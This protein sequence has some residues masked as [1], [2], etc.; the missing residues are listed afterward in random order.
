[1]TDHKEISNRSKVEKNDIL[2]GMIGTIG[3]PVI[4]KENNLF[5]IKNVGLF[6]KNEDLINPRY[7]YHYLSSWF[8][9]KIMLD[10]ELIRGTTQK[11]VALGGLRMLPIP[12]PSLKEQE[13]IIK[14][15]ESRLSVCENIEATIEEAL[16]KAEALESILKK[17]FE[18][19]LLSNEELEVCRR[20]SDWEPAEDLLKR[21]KEDKKGAKSNG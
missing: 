1:M 13:E 12:L 17:A 8:V 5:S 7:L 19:K 21:I 10:Q 3:N 11:F 15:I 4:V 2:F 16:E 6:K 9:E 18:G 14:E 20:E